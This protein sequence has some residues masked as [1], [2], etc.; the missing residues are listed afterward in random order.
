MNVV[1]AVPSPR[2]I[3][4]RAAHGPSSLVADPPAGRWTEG[5]TRPFLPWLLCMKTGRWGIE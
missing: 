2:P 5:L 4:P 3:L 1:Q